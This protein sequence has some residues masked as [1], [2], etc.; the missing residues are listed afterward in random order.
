MEAGRHIK[1]SAY[2]QIV[3]N[4]MAE[5]GLS[6]DGAQ[7]I[8]MRPG[9]IVVNYFLKDEPGQFVIRNDNICNYGVRIPILDD[10]P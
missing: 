7:S 4:I 5:A 9:E 1:R 10:T 2:N 3:D 6:R 8:E